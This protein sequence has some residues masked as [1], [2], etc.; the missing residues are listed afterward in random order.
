MEAA[1]Y[2]NVVD[3]YA[4][5]AEPGDFTA[6][7][8]RLAGGLVRFDMTPKPA[9][10]MLKK[11]F[12]EDWHTEAELTTNSEGTARFKGFYG[13]YDVTIHAGGK[14]IET[15]LHLEKYR[16]ADAYPHTIRI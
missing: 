2:W 6:G 5:L 9:L 10:K 13:N 11:L 3:G 12:T 4:F 8:N 7:E 15:T 16:G 14:T 1:I